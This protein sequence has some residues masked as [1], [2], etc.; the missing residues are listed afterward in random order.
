MMNIGMLDRLVRLLLAVALLY[1]GLFF[2]A[3]SAL[4]LGLTIAAFIPLLTALVG[5]CPLYRLLGICTCPAKKPSSN[6]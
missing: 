2:Y 4:G 1:L 6:L 5:V 3:H